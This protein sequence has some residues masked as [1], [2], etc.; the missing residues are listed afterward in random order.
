MARLYTKTG[1]DG[2]T[3]LMGGDRVSKADPR[4]HAIGEVDELNAALG[5]AR[6]QTL[7]PE[8]EAVLGLAQSHLFSLGAELASD[9]GSL[10]AVRDLSGEHVAILERAIDAMEAGVEPLRHFILP[11]GLPA[12]ASLHLARG[13]CRRAERAL[14]AFGEHEPVRAELRLYLNRLSDLL[15]V[16]AR[17]QNAASGVPETIWTRDAS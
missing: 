1:D 7:A 17:F 14:V 2:T 12:A 5:F 15:F 4:M 13:V 6:S 10:Y 3:G 16:A 8:I 9:E 11:G